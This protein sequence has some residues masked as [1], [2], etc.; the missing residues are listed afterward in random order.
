MNN[1][2]IP[3]VKF[4]N[5]FVNRLALTITFL[6]MVIIC[7]SQSIIDEAFLPIIDSNGQVVAYIKKTSLK[8][9]EHPTG[10][11]KIWAYDDKLNRIGYWLGTRKKLIKM[12][13]K[14]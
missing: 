11:S 9:F 5:L 13:R 8:E 10:G 1:S 4:F 6:L 12:K 7:N 14:Y 3:I 2:S